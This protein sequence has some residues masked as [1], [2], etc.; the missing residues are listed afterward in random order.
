MKHIAVNSLKSLDSG[1][2]RAGEIQTALAE[3]TATR[4]AAE[5]AVLEAHQPLCTELHAALTEQ[6]KQITAYVTS[7]RGVLFGDETTIEIPGGVLVI[8]QRPESVLVEKGQEAAIIERL[9]KAK[10]LQ[11]L[12]KPKVVLDKK[13]LLKD[14]PRLKGITYGRTGESLDIT[15]VT[16]GEKTTLDL[17][18]P[19]PA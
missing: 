18:T 14:R 10:K 16:S 4:S 17:L 9:L 15:P 12:S 5:A 11:F 1:M 6:H 3:A 2:I 7:K 8:R 19:G 13:A